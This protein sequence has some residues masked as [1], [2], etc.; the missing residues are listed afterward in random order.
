MRQ[1]WE[2]IFL[3]NFLVE[4]QRRWICCSGNILKR[5]FFVQ[6]A[7]AYC[8]LQKDEPRRLYIF[9]YKIQ[10]TE[11]NGLSC[12]K[13]LRC[14]RCC[15]FSIPEVFKVESESYLPMHFTYPKEFS[16]HHYRVLRRST[17]NNTLCKI[18]LQLSTSKIP[19]QVFEYLTNA[20]FEPPISNYLF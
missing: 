9:D 11:R 7:N 1:P 20:R 14:K 3:F 19:V 16:L 17:E 6:A 13:D 18:T 8:H 2:Y 12:F 4:A 10:A 15:M 5:F